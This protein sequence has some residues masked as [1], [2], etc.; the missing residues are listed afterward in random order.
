MA[1]R[2]DEAWLQATTYRE[3]SD[4]VARG[5]VETTFATACTVC[6]IARAVIAALVVAREVVGHNVFEEAG[7]QTH[8]AFILFAL[9]LLERGSTDIAAKGRKMW[10]SSVIEYVVFV[11]KKGEIIYAD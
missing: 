10:I 5:A 7:R 2:G 8:L 9:F 4:V 3:V 11:W 6:S 1:A